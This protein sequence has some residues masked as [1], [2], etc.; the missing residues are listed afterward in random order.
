MMNPNL[1]IE[2]SEEVFT[3]F[4]NKVPIV[5]I[6]TGGTFAGIPYPENVETAKKVMEQ[7]REN[8]AI[9]AY[10]SIMHGKIKVG[11]SDSEI[12]DYGKRRGTMLKASRREIPLILA[13]GEYGVMTLAATMVVADLVGIPV[14]SG[15]GLGGVHRGAE[16]TMDISSDL[17][18]I[19]LRN[20]IVV[21]SG[22][23]SILDLN[24]TMEYLETKSIPVIGY[25]T[26]ELPA[27]MAIESGIR[28]PCQM[29]SIEEVAQAYSIKNALNITSGM[30]LM[31]PIS[32]EYAVDAKQMNTVIDEAIE[33][34]K[35]DN[36]R[37]KAITGYLMKYLKDKMGADSMDA[38]KNM[39]I[40]NAVL[41]AKLSAKINQHG[42]F[43]E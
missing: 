1:N 29:D 42:N 41:A 7:I 18:E 8:G 20:V 6:E 4:Q 35:R 19:T 32:A 24:L 12:E 21:C 13:K 36:V 31:N 5:A 37:G 39:I 16:V 26:N 22:A 40:E 11:M 33:C 9:P 2:Y 28:L 10:I 43:A 3:A 38:Q 30:L 14:V 27:Y 17:E 34:S 25:K 15:G 23:K